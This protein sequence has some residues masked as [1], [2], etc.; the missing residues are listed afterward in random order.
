MTLRVA[1]DIGGTFTDLVVVDSESGD[2]RIAK[3]STTPRDLA[4]GVLDVIAA[5]EL[6]PAAIEE[7][8]HGTTVVINALTERTGARTALVTTSGF[9]DVLEIGRGNRPDMYNLVSR[10]PPPFVPR[11]HRFEVRERV[12]RHGTVLVPLD[13]ADA[14]PIAAACE[15]DGIEAVAVCLLHS[16]AHPEHEQAL[17]SLLRERLPGVAVTA[18]SDV[19]REWREFERTS[20][21]VLNAYVQP[22]VD[23]YLGELET[24]LAGAG[25]RGPLLVMQ[26]S[27]GTGSPAAARARP[28]ALVESGPAGGVAGAARI[29]ERIGE[30][31]LIY[32]DIGGTTAKCSLVEDATVPITTEYRIEWRPDWAG[33]PVMVP[34]VDIVEIG[35]G[36]GSIARVD[37][38]GSIVVGPQSAG[39]D[40]GPASY[41]RGGTEPTVT[42]A[43]LVA[44]VLAPDYFLGGQLE[45]R[46]ELAREALRALGEPLGHSVEALASGVIRLADANMISALKLVSVRRG[47]DPRDFAL[48]VGGGGGGMH[49]AAL[50]AELEVRKVIVPPLSG[51]F[52]AWGMCMTAPRADVVRTHILSAGEASDGALAALFA[53]LEDA[54]VATLRARR[55]PTGGRGRP[56]PRGGRALPRPGAH[57]ARARGRRADLGGGPGSGFPRTSPAHI[58]LRP[59]GRLRG[60]AGHLPRLCVRPRSARSGAPRPVG[61]SRVDALTQ[62]PARRRL[63]RGRHA[64]DCR[65]RARRPPHRLLDPRPGCDRGTDD[66]DAGPPRADARGGRVRQPRDLAA[67]SHSTAEAQGFRTCGCWPSP[68]EQ[69]RSGRWRE[70]YGGE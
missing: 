55:H 53:E 68:P 43:K 27:A 51:V 59:G 69:A 48:L 36:G 44:G 70:P 8:V 11:R 3:V 52:S 30:P 47:R 46:P 61:R 35:A 26:S 63:R 2:V 22:V 19:T 16:Y 7:L 34:V 57:G 45:V 20:T 40:P 21:A 24:R 6:E 42:D 54:A 18:S 32:L 13:T 38:G 28:I 17:C 50:G 29:G 66:D 67:L 25:L 33:Y 60:G 56:H 64:P 1:T 37:A 12:D 9:R 14:E 58:H 41:G 31:N 62:T 5:G 23:G 4:Q 49:G 10:K 39:A 15:H 65:L